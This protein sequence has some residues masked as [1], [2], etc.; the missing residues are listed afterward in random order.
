MARKLNIP[1]EEEIADTLHANISKRL[2]DDPDMDPE[3]FHL[4]V[5]VEVTKVLA[6]RRSNGRLLRTRSE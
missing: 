4:M 3:L 2:D 1:D 6:D 5:V